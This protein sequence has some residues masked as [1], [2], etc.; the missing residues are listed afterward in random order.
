MGTKGPGAVPDL[1]KQH[2]ANF[3]ELITERRLTR[4]LVEEL[5]MKRY[6]LFL[7]AE[8]VVKLEPR[9]DVE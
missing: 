3:Y 6:D 9:S 2:V 8:A 4:D 1:S 7:E 5:L